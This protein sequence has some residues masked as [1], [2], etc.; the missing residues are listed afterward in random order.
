MKIIL[1]QG[2]PVAIA[3]KR[4]KRNLDREGFL[5]ELRRREHYVKP[6]DQ[7]RQDTARSKHR[8]AKLALKP[9]GNETVA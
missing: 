1:R 9:Y 2:E 8:R 7:R 3:L 6:S 4:L 5:R